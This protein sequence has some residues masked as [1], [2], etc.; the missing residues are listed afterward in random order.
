MAIDYHKLKD[1]P[2]QDVIQTYTERDTMLYALSLGLGHD[3]LDKRA[4]R[5]VYE[6]G[7]GLLALPTMAT[8]LGFPGFW[9]K[10]PASGIDWVR[11]VHG[12][13]GLT[14]H[15]PLPPSA[16]VVGR[17]R[18]THIVDKGLGKGA[19]VTAERT[20]RD[21][22]SGALYATIRH[23]S[24]CR[25]DGGFSASGQPSDTPAIALQATPEGP[26]PFVLEQPTRADTALLYRLLADRNP[27]HADPEVAGAA[28][29]VR[30][31]LHGLASYGLAGAAIVRT[32]CDNNPIQLR[33]I[34]TRF[35]SPMYPGETLRTEMWRSGGKVQ[36]RARVLE[37]DSIVL[38]HGR[39]EIAE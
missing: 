21:Q 39:A 36:F 25:G 13:N 28:G 7:A 26:A 14:I 1:W 16:T 27:L 15:N 29:F 38:S 32:L 24:F 22:A 31:I 35:S 8:V 11:I 5:F 17:T 23:V 30:P 18:V 33:S 2:F 9:M 34:D 3:P 20:V 37:R 12:E 4:L 19:I 6:G 10:D